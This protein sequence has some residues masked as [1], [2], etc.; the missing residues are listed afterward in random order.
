MYWHHHFVGYHFRQGPALQFAAKLHEIFMQASI[1]EII[2]TYIRVQ[3]WKGFIPLGSIMAA[4]QT[5]QLSYLWSWEIWAALSSPAMT[6]RG[7]VLFM[8]LVPTMILLAGV[9]GPST[10]VAMLPRQ[11]ISKPIDSVPFIIKKSP[12]AL[13]LNRFD[14][15]ANKTM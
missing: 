10:A 2:L 3:A 7:K 14:F 13:F 6:K 15:P 4:Y 12:T 9:V 11:M 8:A 5:S 1:A